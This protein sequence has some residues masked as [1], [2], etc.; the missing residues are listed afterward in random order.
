[1]LVDSEMGMPLNLNNFENVWKGQDEG[2]LFESVR[3]NDMLTKGLNPVADPY[4]QLDPVDQLLLAPMKRKAEAKGEAK[5]AAIAPAE[6]SWMR[7]GN[8]FSRKAGAKKR[9]ATA[10]AK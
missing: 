2:E 4:R 3:A 6:V 9:E 5:A 8:L 1:M 10:A 7:T